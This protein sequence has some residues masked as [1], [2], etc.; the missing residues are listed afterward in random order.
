MLPF[1]SSYVALGDSTWIDLHPA[2]DAGETDGT[3]RI[4][5]VLEEVGALP[6]HA[7]E[8]TNA[9]IRRLAD[10]T[11]NT[12]LAD[13]HAHFLGHGASAPEAERWYRRRSLG[14]PNARGANEVRRVWREALDEVN[15]RA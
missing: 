2:L 9:H 5:G 3:G 4:P 13:V 10:G 11:P 14:E 1:F 7:L 6:V 12:A 8:E 15:L